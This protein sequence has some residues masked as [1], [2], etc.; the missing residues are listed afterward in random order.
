MT[1]T[2][3][4]QTAGIIAVLVVLVLTLTVTL[5]RLVALPLAGAAL[6]L[7]TAANVCAAP[8]SLPASTSKEDTR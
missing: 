5:L 2:H 7:D 1:T 3:M 4:I 8:L 6:L